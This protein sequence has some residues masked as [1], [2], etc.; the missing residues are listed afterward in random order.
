M[1]NCDLTAVAGV[2][3]GPLQNSAHVNFTIIQQ[4]TSVMFKLRNLVDLYMQLT[5]NY[6]SVSQDNFL[7]YSSNVDTVT[8]P[9]VDHNSIRRDFATIAT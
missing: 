6:I 7:N 4:Q 9:S 3:V 2:S 5:F 8:D 1:V